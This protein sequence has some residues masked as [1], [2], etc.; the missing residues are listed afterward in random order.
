M[1]SA[2]LF[3]RCVCVCVRCTYAFRKD[4]NTFREDIKLLLYTRNNEII[5]K[6]VFSVMVSEL[7]D[8][9]EQFA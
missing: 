9:C 5:V 6:D 3:V 4:A 2:V 7:P 1:E 8:F